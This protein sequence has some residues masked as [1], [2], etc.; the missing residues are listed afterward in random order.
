VI[1]LELYRVRGAELRRRAEFIRAAQA[2][3]PL[4]I[5]PVDQGASRA[6]RL[7]G[8]VEEMQPAAY[9]DA[10][11]ARADEEDVTRGLSI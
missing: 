9:G 8:A 3:S 4:D 6:R 11:A 1:T 7:G 5:A 2:R 10:G